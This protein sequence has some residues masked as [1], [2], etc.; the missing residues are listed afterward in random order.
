MKWMSQLN[1]LDTQKNKAIPLA[2]RS[3]FHHQDNKMA[4]TASSFLYQLENKILQ[5]Y[6]SNHTTTDYIGWT[7]IG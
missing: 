5:I 1:I 4:N 6:R 7:A 2:T 3:L